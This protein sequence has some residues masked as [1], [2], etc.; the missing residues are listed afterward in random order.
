MEKIIAY[1]PKNKVR[2]LMAG[3]LFDGHR[4]PGDRLGLRTSDFHIH[5]V[6]EQLGITRH[7]LSWSAPF[8]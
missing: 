5:T 1:T 4:A 7:D 2:I 3:S 8:L 6:K